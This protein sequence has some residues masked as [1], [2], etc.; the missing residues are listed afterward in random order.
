M[1]RHGKT[2]RQISADLIRKFP[3]L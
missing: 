1:D 3:D 2:S